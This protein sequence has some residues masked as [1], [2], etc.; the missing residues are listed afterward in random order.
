VFG[1]TFAILGA[2]VSSAGRFLIAASFLGVVRR[3]PGPVH[4][5]RFLRQAQAGGLLRQRGHAYVF[6]HGLLRDALAGMAALDDRTSPSTPEGVLVNG[7][8]PVAARGTQA[9]ATVEQGAAGTEGSV[10]TTVPAGRP[11]AARRTADP[12]RG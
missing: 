4:T 5:F 1:A 7:A 6:S 2:M 8:A 3:W 12:E 10:G 9:A 11:V